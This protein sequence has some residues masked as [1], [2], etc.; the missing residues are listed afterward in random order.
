MSRFVK[1][2]KVYQ[3]EVSNRFTNLFEV[4][5][6]CTVRSSKHSRN[7]IWKFNVYNKKTT[8][9]VLLNKV[10]VINKIENDK[11]TLSFLP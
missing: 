11:K 4:L 2:N 10:S 1:P 8:T 6:W 5:R 7:T 3:A 9:F